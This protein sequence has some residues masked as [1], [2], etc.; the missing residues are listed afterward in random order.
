MGLLF[1]QQPPSKLSEFRQTVTNQFN[2]LNKQQMESIKFFN[3]I[4]SRGASLK[5]NCDAHLTIALKGKNRKQSSYV[6]YLQNL[7]KKENIKW[8]YA[9]VRVYNGQIYIEEGISLSG[10]LIYR[11]RDISNRILVEALFNF[12]SIKKPNT[13]D[14]S[15]IVKLSATK[16]E[17]GYLLSAI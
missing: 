12:L 11:M 16:F 10:Y 4:K 5:N 1:K 6:F 17:K 3:P 14:E 8:K 13:E 15:I 2:H 7:M 9:N